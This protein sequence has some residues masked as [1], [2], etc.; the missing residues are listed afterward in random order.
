M[1]NDVHD[2][3]TWHFSD[4]SFEVLIA[5]GSNEAPMLLHSLHNAVVGICSLVAAFK[6]LETGILRDSEG[7]AVLDSKFLQLCH[8]AVSDVGYALAEEA[9]HAGLED[10]QFVLDG[11]V[12][13]VGIN[14]DAVWWS[15]GVVMR[16]EETRWFF[17]PE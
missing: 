1:R 14:K 15:E 2:R 9:V 16:E 4:P 17:G 3:D 6:P 5:G 7:E 8:D 12:D 13:E 11:K 10:V